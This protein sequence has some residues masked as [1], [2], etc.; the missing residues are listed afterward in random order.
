RV[1]RGERIELLV[2][3]ALQ[4]RALADSPRIDAH[5]VISGTYGR[6]E[7]AHHRV[8]IVDRRPTRTTRIDEH[9]VR[10]LAA[11]RRDDLDRQGG[12]RATWLVVVDGDGDGGAHA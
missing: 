9:A 10:R 12:R 8:G 7:L 2:G 4:G 5:D 6:A 1:G 11:G 3:Q